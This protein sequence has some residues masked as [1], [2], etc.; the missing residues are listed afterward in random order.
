MQAFSLDRLDFVLLLSLT[1][2]AVSSLVFQLDGSDN[3]EE[4]FFKLWELMFIIS[5]FVSLIAALASVVHET[6][7]F[8]LERYIK[9][10]VLGRVRQTRRANPNLKLDAGVSQ[11]IRKY[12]S[13]RIG[14]ANDFELGSID[15]ELLESFCVSALRAASDSTDPDVL[16]LL[17]QVSARPF[18]R[19]ICRSVAVT[20]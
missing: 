11:S 18:V 5:V 9:R 3:L 16:E 1:I 12:C 8:F 7:V 17:T 13:N 10:R 6:R 20:L 4:P 19:T 15:L 14:D 2:I